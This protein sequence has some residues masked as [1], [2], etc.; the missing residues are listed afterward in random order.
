MDRAVHA[1]P[2]GQM[3]VGRVDDRVGLFQRNVALMEFQHLA[4]KFL[5]HEGPQSFKSSA[6]AFEFNSS[7]VAC[8]VS[9]FQSNVQAGSKTRSRMNRPTAALP[10]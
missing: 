10:T 5:L 6:K 8:R 2:A 9:W 4:G 3:A 7:P 1:A